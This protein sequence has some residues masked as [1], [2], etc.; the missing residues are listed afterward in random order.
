MYKDKLIS[1]LISLL[2]LSVISFTCIADVEDVI[3]SQAELLKSDAEKMK[4]ERNTVKNSKNGV[5]LGRQEFINTCA[6]CHGKDGKGNGP[7]SLHLATKPKDL[8]LIRINNNG[9]FP[10]KK[11]YD[12]IDGREITQTHGSRT[13]PIW[14]DHY[15]AE[16]WLEVSTQYAETL[17]RGR[18]LELLLYL[19]SIQDN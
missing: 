1:T 3:A 9:E 10:F 2:A 12:I 17:A 15:S 18:I 14:G 16:S 13:M 8:T 5:E 7:F 4:D 11:L 19:E 6:M